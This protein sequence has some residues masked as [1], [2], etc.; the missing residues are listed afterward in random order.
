MES[1]K[2]SYFDQEQWLKELNEQPSAECDPSYPSV[3]TSTSSA[4]RS[5]ITVEEPLAELESENTETWQKLHGHTIVAGERLQEKINESLVA[6]VKEALNLWKIY[7]V[8]M[9]LVPLGCFSARTKLSVA[10]KKAGR[11][12]INRASACCIS[13]VKCLL[14]LQDDPSLVNINLDD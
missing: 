4:S 14:L 12:V 6:F 2:G 13:P 7:E 10:R 1:D 11:S 3:S 5:K 9:D 8:K